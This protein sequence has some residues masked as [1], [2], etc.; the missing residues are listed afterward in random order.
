MT[1]H[2]PSFEENWPPRQDYERYTTIIAEEYWPH[3]L[4]DANFVNEQLT[5]LDENSPNREKIL[6][7][8]TNRLSTYFGHEYD[9]QEAM[10]YARALIFNK[11]SQP[12]GES[13]QLNIRDRLT[14]D[15]LTLDH[16]N[17]SRQVQLVFTPEMQ[18]DPSEPITY[19]VLADKFHLYNLKIIAKTEAELNDEKYSDHMARFIMGA[20]QVSKFTS[21]DAFL[22]LP[23]EE[24][25]KQLA[26]CAV[27]LG[28]Q[29][30]PHYLT[31]NIEIACSSFY[32]IPDDLAGCN[33]PIEIFYVNQAVSGLAPDEQYSPIG[34]IRDCVFLEQ[35]ED[36]LGEHRFTKPSDFNLGFGEP[37]L[38]IYS[39]EE[40]CR[41]Y[42][43]PS[44]I[45]DVQVKD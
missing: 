16:F 20:E 10:V 24:Q 22:S 25:H 13:L 2:L 17:D 44:S 42:I 38:Y 35:Q 4:E 34:N 43:I 31:D 3:F 37:C 8:Y 18:P 14:F 30:V 5:N 41:Y 9:E 27:N 32:A 7:F 1:S 26:S 11:D 45:T 40:K 19:H 21:N 6:E 39:E 33:F 36:P 12:T 29:L 28:S 23:I 15:G